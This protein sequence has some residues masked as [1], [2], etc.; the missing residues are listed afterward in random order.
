MG[1]RAPR[2]LPLPA[3]SQTLI[4]SLWTNSH[5]PFLYL[6]PRHLYPTLRLEIRV[7]MVAG[8]VQKE[9]ASK[10]RQSEGLVKAVPA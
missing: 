5:L 3:S 10:S 7:G 2:A 6:S 1:F 9:E 4:R 8:A